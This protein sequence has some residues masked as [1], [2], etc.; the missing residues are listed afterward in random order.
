M[1][2]WPL[3]SLVTFVPLVGT[4]F[5]LMARG[6]EAVVAQ[7]ARWI[8]LWTSLIDFVLSVVLWLE[9]DPNTADFQFVESARMRIVSFTGSY[10]VI[11]AR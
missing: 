7:N 2:H 9:F 10:R 3:L 5:I 1:S 8:A 6:D 11:A 4:A